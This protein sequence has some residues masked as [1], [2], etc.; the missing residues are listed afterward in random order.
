[1]DVP[2]TRHRHR[3]ARRLQLS[4]RDADH[5]E[6]E[7]VIARYKVIEEANKAVGF[8]RVVV[9]RRLIGH[10]SSRPRFHFKVPFAVM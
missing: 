7:A 9:G 6:N 5:A 1:M 2:E 4:T 8:D 10:G 3:Q